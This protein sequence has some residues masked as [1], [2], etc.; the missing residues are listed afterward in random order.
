MFSLCREGH[1]RIKPDS[2]EQFIVLSVRS[3]TLSSFVEVELS[4]V[5]GASIPR[6]LEQLVEASIEVAV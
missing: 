2:V 4:L 5:L 3:Q 6:D 1:P